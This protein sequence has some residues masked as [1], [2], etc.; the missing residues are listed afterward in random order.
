MTKP[1]SR[2]PLE[3]HLES[4]I[5][6]VH[7]R[8]K[9]T[10]VTVT[11]SVQGNAKGT[12]RRGRD[13]DVIP[14]ISCQ[15]CFSNDDNSNKKEKEC[16]FANYKCPKCSIPYC[17]VAC[18]QRHGASCTESF[19][20]SRVTQEM[21]LRQKED[22]D[23]D[24]K[25]TSSN[26]QIHRILNR[27]HKQQQQQEQQQLYNEPFQDNDTD[28]DD[29]MIST[30]ELER[31]QD[32]LERGEGHDIQ[33]SPELQA[34]FER[35]IQAGNLNHIVKPWHPWWRP[36]FHVDGDAN[37]NNLADD[38]DDNDDIGIDAMDLDEQILQIPP[39][40]Q[41]IH[42]P[43]PDLSFNLVSILTPFLKL[44]F[45]LADQFLHDASKRQ[46]P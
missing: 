37:D 24:E 40:S 23:A 13:G 42:S 19:Y 15:I 36:L 29:N 43:P 46:K 32:A 2:S 10:V 44:S 33:L 25:S 14:P 12:T 27:V 28:A 34:A 41:F 38:C 26:N 9:R 11:D 3:S 17:S 35:D 31:L 7:P 8:W 18:Y 16:I 20:R 6:I 21:D 22:H 39:L 45:C 5:P 30:A 4:L 1:C